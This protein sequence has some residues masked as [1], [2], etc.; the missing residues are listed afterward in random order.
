LF[1]IEDELKAIKSKV[2]E[3]FTQAEKDALRKEV[4]NLLAEKER[5]ERNVKIVTKSQQALFGIKV[6]KFS[7]KTPQNLKKRSRSS[8]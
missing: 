6:L 5:I 4:E 7:R 2:R 3:A 1:E 8:F